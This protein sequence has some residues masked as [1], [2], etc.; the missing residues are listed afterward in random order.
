MQLLTV[1]AEHLN[2]RLQP[3]DVGII[4]ARA[5]VGKT[6]CLAQIALADLVAGHAVLHVALDATV[7]HVRE[8]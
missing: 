8:W 1:I 2:R 4:G 5:G 6:A 7:A 3:G